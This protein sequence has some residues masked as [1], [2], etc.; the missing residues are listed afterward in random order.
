MFTGLH[1]TMLNLPLDPLRNTSSSSD[2]ISLCV[3]LQENCQPLTLPLLFSGQYFRNSNPSPSLPW[4]LSQLKPAHSPR[5]PDTGPTP[6]HPQGAKSSLGDFPFTPCRDQPNPAMDRGNPPNPN[7]DSHSSPRSSWHRGTCHTWQGVEDPAWDTST[8]AQQIMPALHAQETSRDQGHVSQHHPFPH[9][10]KS[11]EP[12]N[13]GRG[14]ESF[15]FF[16]F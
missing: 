4:H 11:T 8:L 2:C 1:L 10:T 7:R 15:F 3:L 16:L 13:V 9:G 12:Q 14:R 6:E 5:D